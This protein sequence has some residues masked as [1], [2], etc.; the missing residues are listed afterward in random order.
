MP[1]Y[2]AFLRAQKETWDSVYHPNIETVYYY[3]GGSGWNGNELSLDCPEDF[4]MMHWKHKLAID[5]VYEKDWDIIFRTNSSAYINKEKLYDFACNLPVYN[6]YGGWLLGDTLP[7]IEWNGVR[8][9][10]HVISGAGIFYSKDIAKIIS[11]ET[12]SETDIEEDVLMG[13]ILYS[14]GIPVTF[15]DKSRCDLSGNL[16]NYKKT[17]HYRIKSQNRDNDIKLMYKLHKKIIK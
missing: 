13:R 1:P 10:Q 9:K 7:V 4:Y 2:D 17:Y 14:K 6:L 12:G 8:I 11:E 16:N 15:D 3:G 5:A